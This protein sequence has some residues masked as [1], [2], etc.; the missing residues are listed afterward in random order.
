VTSPFHVFVSAPLASPSALARL[1][2]SGALVTVAADGLGMEDP[3]F[4][5]SPGSYEALIVLL[6]TPVDAAL[7]A[8]A[9]SLRVVATVSVGT[10]HIDRAACAARGI[11]VTNTPGVL[12]E[13]TADFTFGLLLAAARRVAEGDR[14]M[15]RGDFRGWGPS[16]LV[17]ARVHGATLGIVGLGRI[18][19]AVARRARGFG[20]K[21]L[22]AQRTQLSPEM[23]RALGAR[24]V[25]VDALFR[26][27]DLVSLCCPLTPETRRIA[28]AAR[29]RSMKPGSVFV[30]ASRGGC[31]D[32][33]ALAEV[34]ARGPLAAA[35]L[36]VYEEEPRAHPALL[37]LENV[38]LTPHIASAE[39]PT[40]EAMAELA[41]ENVLAVM[42][43]REPPSRADR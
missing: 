41:V 20:M 18:G 13:A 15:R 11:T 29:L 30:N 28:S 22:Y 16:F 25:S 21:T 26:E 27:S 9:A 4:A 35:G 39:G 40:R 12:T 14:V 31:V 37:T 34:L 36:D 42:A 32:E 8:R 7:L 23:E 43:G 2:A 3:R 38:V 19:S 33:A 6:N 24:F 5:D 10:D 1:T 17:G